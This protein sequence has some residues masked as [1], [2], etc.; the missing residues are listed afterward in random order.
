M[1]TCPTCHQQ[2][3]ASTTPA[4][5]AAHGLLD[6]PTADGW[7]VADTR[8]RFSSP[9]CYPAGDSRVEPVDLVGM[10]YSATPVEKIPPP[11]APLPVMTVT[12]CVPPMR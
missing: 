11:P 4:P 7:L 12:Y 5:T 9:F 2:L 1:S 10:H 6:A 8:L 3:P